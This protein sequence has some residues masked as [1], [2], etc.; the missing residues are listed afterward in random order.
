MARVKAKVYQPC[1][2]VIGRKLSWKSVGSDRLYGEVCKVYFDHGPDPKNRNGR[3]LHKKITVE[4]NDG[5][6]INMSAA[7]GDLKRMGVV[8]E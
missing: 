7:P 5:R 8:A 6:R 2:D 1:V 4:L 3:L